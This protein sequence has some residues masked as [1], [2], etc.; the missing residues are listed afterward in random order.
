MKRFIFSGITLMMG[1]L[2][3]TRCEKDVPKP[4]NNNGDTTTAISS[5]IKY[6]NNW[7]EY[8]MNAVYYWDDYLPDNLNPNTEPDPEEYFKK[9]LYSSDHFSWIT[10]DFEALMSE[11]EGI[12]VSMGYS[13]SFGRYTNSDGVFMI[14]E[15]VIPGSPADSA[16]LKRGDIIVSI[17]GIDLDIDNYYDL[18]KLTSYSVTYGVL[19]DDGIAKTDST[20]SMVAQEVV[21]DPVI[22][23]DV[24]EL[25]DLKIGYLVYVEFKSGKSNEFNDS[26]GLVFD[27][28]AAAGIDELVVD[29]RYNPGGVLSATAYLASAIAPLSVVQANEVMVRFEYNDY[30]NNV[31]LQEE[32]TNSEN[33]VLRFPQNDHNINLNRVYFLTTRGT[34]SASEFLMTGLYPYMNVVQVGENTYGKYAGA[35]VIPDLEDP[36]KHN[37]GLVPIV[38]KYANANGFT[39][40]EDGLVPNYYIEDELIGALPFG[41]LQDPVLN[42]ALQVIQGTKSGLPA[43]KS[44]KPA[45]SFERID[46]EISR[47]K[48]NLFVLPAT[49]DLS[50]KK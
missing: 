46:D 6:I 23:K 48:R 28:F 49:E 19:T 9:L 25:G 3:F 24:I 1:I 14:V 11:I 31:F 35:W 39:D 41:N 45:Y 50:L 4:E 2:M 27:E 42:M 12:S 37:W 33:L 16:G 34:A 7:I 44:E 5:Q 20:V 29:L 40:F 17:N 22:Y 13:P 26:L 36:P 32:G 18:Y 38:F 43:L 10:D 21:L 8:V 47:Y 30:W 15:Y